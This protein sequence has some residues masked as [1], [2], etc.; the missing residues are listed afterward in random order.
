MVGSNL[1]FAADGP[2]PKI[3]GRSQAAG[4]S[5]SEVLFMGDSVAVGEALPLAAAFNA[6]GVG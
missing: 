5:L 1:I 4:P 3:V 2:K 6:G